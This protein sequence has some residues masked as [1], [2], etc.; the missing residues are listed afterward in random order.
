MADIVLAQGAEIAT[1][2]DAARVAELHRALRVATLRITR[3]SDWVDMD[4]QPY[5]SASG[6]Q[7]LAPL[8]RIRTRGVR[9]ERVEEPGGGYTVVVTGEACSEVLD[10]D[11]WQEVVGT[12]SSEDR[13]LTKGGRVKA[14]YGDVLKKAMTNFTARAIKQLIGLGGIT[15][16][17]LAEHGIRRQDAP[18]V[19][20]ASPTREGWVAIKIRYQDRDRLRAICRSTAGVSPTWDGET[21]TWRVPAEV[22]SHQEV[23]AMIEAALAAK[24]SAELPLEEP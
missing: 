20:Y 10:P 6:A 22:A 23:K 24:S 18:Q 9:V 2:E 1:A 21:K 13:F 3:A 19:H 11:G 4:G 14:A 7:R 12:A 16:E 15:W 8:F 5:L 17:D